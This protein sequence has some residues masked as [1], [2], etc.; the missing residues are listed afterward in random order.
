VV[1][2]IFAAFPDDGALMNRIRAYHKGHAAELFVCELWIT[3]PHCQ[4]DGRMPNREELLRLVDAV[5]R[6]L[7]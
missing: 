4:A 7:R 5:A 2:I 3:M 6:A 1:I